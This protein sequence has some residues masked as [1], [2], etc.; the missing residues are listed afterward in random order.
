MCGRIRCASSRWCAPIARGLA[1]ADPARAATYEANAAAY[2]AR[3][4]ELDRWI[5]AAFEPVPAAR[6]KVVTSHDAFA[7]FAAR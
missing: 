7:Y 3:L 2:V 5:V 6:R 4:G 1:A